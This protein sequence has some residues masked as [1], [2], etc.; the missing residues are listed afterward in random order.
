[1]FR[2]VTTGTGRPAD[3]GAGVTRAP[4]FQVCVIEP[5][6][7][8]GT[9]VRLLPLMPVHC[10]GR[11]D[12]PR[13]DGLTWK[14]SADSSADRRASRFT[15]FDARD[16]GDGRTESAAP[17]GRDG[18]RCCAILRPATS[19]ESLRRLSAAGSVLS[20]RALAHPGARPLQLR[21]A[22]VRAAAAA[23]TAAGASGAVTHR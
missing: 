6:P 9:P 13:R 22:T 5:G 10:R 7:L 11:T 15:V 23:K 8:A 14:L 17:P 19:D 16:T 18:R 1:M 21:R 4:E 2:K 12:P 3:V 20:V